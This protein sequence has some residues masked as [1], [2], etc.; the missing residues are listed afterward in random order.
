MKLKLIKSSG[1]ERPFSQFDDEK[2]LKEL[3]V[4]DFDTIHVIDFNPNGI[5]VQNNID[6][7]K[8]T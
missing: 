6:D 5:L 7:L 8:K 3:C 2:K 1:E 4:E